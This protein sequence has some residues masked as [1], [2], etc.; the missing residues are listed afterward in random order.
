MDNQVVK[1]RIT[2]PFGWRVHPITKAKSFHDGVDIGCPIG[3]EVRT[4]VDCLV[5]AVYDHTIG[6]KT[7]IIKDLNSNDRFGF[8]HLNDFKVRVGDVKKQGDIIALSGN[9]GRSTAPHLHF[10]YAINGV[11]NGNICTGH[12]FVN[13]ESKLQWK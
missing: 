7:I 1:G 8:C 13:P 9:T 5:A 2:S 3:S 4:P 12:Q 6:G 11:W 10:S